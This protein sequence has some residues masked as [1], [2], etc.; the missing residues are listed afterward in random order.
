MLGIEPNEVL[1]VALDEDRFSRRRATL[2]D[3]GG[4]IAGAVVFSGHLVDAICVRPDAE[5]ADV[6][7]PLEAHPERFLEREDIVVHAIDG[8]VNVAGSADEHGLR[9]SMVAS[10]AHAQI[11]GR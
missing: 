8:A 9:R 11:P 3:P 5:V 7:H 4:E 1:V 6:K 2:R 10:A